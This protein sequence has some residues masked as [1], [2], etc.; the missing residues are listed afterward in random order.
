MSQKMKKTL[1][2]I[3][4]WAVVTSFI[5]M[6]VT[7]IIQVVAR[8]ALPW[9]PHWTEELARFSFIYMISLGSGLAVKDRIYVNVS[10][11]LDRFTP[12]GK[13]IMDNLILSCIIL[14][15]GTMFFYSFPLIR[16]VTL[17]NSASLKINMGVIYFSMT[18]MGFF[19]MIYSFFEILQNF[20]NK[21]RG[22]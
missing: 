17:Q 22:I 16:I 3:L 15:M 8:Y 1:D 14:L 9:S 12:K 10:S 13:F 4:E 20:K 21:R 19:V 18:C 6:I 7:V 5:L 2:K 11:I